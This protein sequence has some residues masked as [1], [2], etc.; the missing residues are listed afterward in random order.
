MGWAAVFMPGL[1]AVRVLPFVPH[2]PGQSN[3]MAVE[4]FIFCMVTLASGF[5][6]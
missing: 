2:R 4:E 5:A 3:M 6:L 1:R